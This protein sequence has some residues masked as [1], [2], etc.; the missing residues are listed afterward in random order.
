MT[1]EDFVR[2]LKQRGATPESDNAIIAEM[3]GLAIRI[4]KYDGERGGF[5]FIFADGSILSSTGGALSAGCLFCE[6]MRESTEHV[7][8]GAAVKDFFTVKAATVLWAIHGAVI[9][10]CQ[11][12]AETAREAGVGSAAALKDELF[13]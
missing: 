12:C 7:L 3:V 9:Q 13:H 2:R 1:A 8:G 6:T 4:I 5:R 11:R 10:L